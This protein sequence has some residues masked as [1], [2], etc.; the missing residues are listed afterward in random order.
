MRLDFIFCAFIEDDHIFNVTV[1]F[2]YYFWEAS[3]N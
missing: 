2:P 1:N 3:Y